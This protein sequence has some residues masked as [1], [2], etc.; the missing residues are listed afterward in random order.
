M[1]IEGTW[2]IARR[3]GRLSVLVTIVRGRNR[4]LAKT[5]CDLDSTTERGFACDNSCGSNQTHLLLV[6]LC[7]VCCVLCDYYLPHVLRRLPFGAGVVWTC[8]RTW[9]DVSTCLRPMILSC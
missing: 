9:Y 4:K 2:R 8:G 1:H 3:S 5:P 7:D 6:S